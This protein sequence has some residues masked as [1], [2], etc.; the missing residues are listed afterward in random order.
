MILFKKVATDIRVAEP[1]QDIMSTSFQTNDWESE[2]EESSNS[3]EEFMYMYVRNKE[4]SQVPGLTEINLTKDHP[5]IIMEE[6]ILGAN[7]TIEMAPQIQEEILWSPHKDQVA[8]I[9]E[10]G[11]RK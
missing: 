2:E 6:E 7:A 8:V 9:G 1:C 10:T 4:S 5:I 3:S 11:I